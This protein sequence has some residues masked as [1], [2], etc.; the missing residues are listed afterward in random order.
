MRLIHWSVAVMNLEQL[1]ASLVLPRPA[2]TPPKR[3]L[4]P[5]IHFGVLE[6]LN[7][8]QIPAEAG[9]EGAGSQSPSHLGRGI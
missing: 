6:Q 4:L 8:K 3:K 2:G 7:Q 9:W 1:S 5:V